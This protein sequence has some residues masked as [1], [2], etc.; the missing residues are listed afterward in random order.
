MNGENKMRNDLETLMYSDKEFHALYEISEGFNDDVNKNHRVR[1][2]GKA[3]SEFIDKGSSALIS[4][5][6]SIVKQ[7]L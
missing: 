3:F 5:H 4:E 6:L 1:E 7:L 2:D